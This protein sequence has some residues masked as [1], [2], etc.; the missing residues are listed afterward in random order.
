M[1]NESRSINTKLKPSNT[2]EIVHTNQHPDDPEEGQHGADDPEEG[3]QGA[4]DKVVEFDG[5]DS[6]PYSKAQKYPGN[7][8]GL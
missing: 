8:R 6:R 5:L 7:S 1:T 4:D 3:K 2:S